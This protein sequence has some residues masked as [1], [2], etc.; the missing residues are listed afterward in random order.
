VA[1]VVVVGATVVV[2]AGALARVVD[3]VGAADFVPPPEQAARAPTN[4][5]AN[6]AA[7]RRRRCCAPM[8]VVW[9]VVLIG[10]A[11][12][13]FWLATRFEPHW[14]ASDGTRFTCRVQEID[15]TG[16]PVSRWYEARAQI[17]EGKVVI[18]KKVLMRRGVPVDARVVSARSDEAPR[19]R[20]IY[21]L[22]G[23]PLLAVRVPTHS[24]AVTRL[25]A[26]LD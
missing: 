20:A 14:S 9:A 15:P 4:T 2:G 10:V 12:L 22:A 5:R 16:R 24:P 8:T 18:T 21:L 26:L 11:G 6:A 17:V 23:S 25:E 19:G 13:L 7:K 1:N 3:E